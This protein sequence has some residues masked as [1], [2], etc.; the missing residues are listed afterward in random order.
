MPIFDNF[1]KK[2]L[3]LK[4]DVMLSRNLAENAKNSFAAR[5]RII[6]LVAPKRAFINA[7]S[8]RKFCLRQTLG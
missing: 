6:L 1:S 4:S 5:H 7:D 8:R 2:F 3:G